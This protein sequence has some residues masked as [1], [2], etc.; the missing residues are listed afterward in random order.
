MRRCEDAFG[1]AWRSKYLLR[2]PAALSLAN[3]GLGIGIHG[4]DSSSKHCRDSLDC[5]R[6]GKMAGW[7]VLKV[8]TAGRKKGHV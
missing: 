1:T 5:G 7:G 6:G 3:S 4:P 8:E 2:S